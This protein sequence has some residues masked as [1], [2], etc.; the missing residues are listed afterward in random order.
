MKFMN[1]SVTASNQC[2]QIG[3]LFV[4]LGDNFF[5]KPDEVFKLQYTLHTVYFA[6]HFFSSNLVST[7]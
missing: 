3:R 2:D 6:V 4:V 7:K 1:S 5:T